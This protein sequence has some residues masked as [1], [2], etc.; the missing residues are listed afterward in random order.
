MGYLVSYMLILLWYQCCAQSCACRNNDAIQVPMGKAR[1][2]KAPIR[3]KYSLAAQYV[4]NNRRM[5]MPCSKTP[6]NSSC[7]AFVNRW[8]MLLGYHMYSC[9]ESSATNRR[10]APG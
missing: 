7:D 9:G 3:Q 5:D 1:L 6:N 10:V 4:E 8:K 2:G